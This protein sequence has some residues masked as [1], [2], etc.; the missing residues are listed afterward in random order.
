MKA[1]LG[2]LPLHELLSHWQQQPWSLRSL[3][4]PLG[5]CICNANPLCREDGAEWQWDLACHTASVHCTVFTGVTSMQLAVTA[6]HCCRAAALARCWQA[7]IL[8]KDF[9][10]RKPSLNSSF[11][12]F[13]VAALLCFRFEFE[14]GEDPSPSALRCS[15]GGSPKLLGTLRSPAAG[16]HVQVCRI[17]LTWH[18]R[19]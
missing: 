6:C 15:C 8:P 5:P 12:S 4:F 9:N 1:F 11:S 18:R 19:A 17:R 7:L 16:G 14:A 3:H 2:L 10:G 13:H